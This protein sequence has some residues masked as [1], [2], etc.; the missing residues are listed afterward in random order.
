[1]N[2]NFYKNT[3]LIIVSLLCC[4]SILEIA[5]RLINPQKFP[6]NYFR[7]DKLSGLICGSP[8]YLGYWDSEY[9]RIVIKT[10]KYGFRGNV[11]DQSKKS[12]AKVLIL[13]DSF[14]NAKQ[15]NFKD[16]FGCLLS[17]NVNDIKIQ[18]MEVGA[19]TWGQGDELQWL[20][21][22]C[23]KLKPDIVILSVFL[24][25]DLTIDNMKTNN[26]GSSTYLITKHGLISKRHKQGELINKIKQYT[27]YQSDL[28]LFVRQQI[29]LHLSNKIIKDEKESIRISI[30]DK[31]RINIYLKNED[32]RK[33][34][35]STFFKLIE[36]FILLGQEK[37]FKIV[38]MIIPW[39]MALKESYF[40]HV[41]EHF[42]LPK[43]EYLRTLPQ[44]EI[45]IYMKKQ[46]IDFID[47][48]EVF[49]KQSDP[50]IAYG[51][52]DKHLS[53][54]GHKFISQELIRYFEQT[55]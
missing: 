35:Y 26:I 6:D 5:F 31:S 20:R 52:K 48:S 47:L 2:K 4:F 53:P 39:H 25:N 36:Q 40:N 42:N 17:E 18:V 1:M 24:G 10:N 15:V 11:F 29:S 41:L 34:Y 22:Y 33:I 28:Y 27:I 46:K 16:T 12:H 38:P 54:V 45:G 37:N 30:H 43:D 23:D 3:I 51:K 44:T 32:V 9:G 55:N 19:G 50:L 7:R 49:L 8:D 13:G 21:T 14:V